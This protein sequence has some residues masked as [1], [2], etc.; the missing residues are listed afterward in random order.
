MK[1]VWVSALLLGCATQQTSAV[2]AQVEKGM[3][4]PTVKSGQV[5][6]LCTPG[7]A[8]VFIDGISVGACSQFEG[9]PSGL[10]LSKGLRQVVV[11][12]NG[13]LPYSSYLD[14]DG[15]RVALTIDLIPAQNNRSTP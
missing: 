9:K 12:K 4:R 15:T 6:L 14:S 8:E 2:V 5:R 3:R 7:D 10:T 11:K 1:W 13:F